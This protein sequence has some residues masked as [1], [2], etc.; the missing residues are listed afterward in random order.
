MHYQVN[1]QL[2]P[3]RTNGDGGLEAYVSY[4]GIAFQCYAPQDPLTIEQQTTGQKRKVTVDTQKLIDRTAKTV[5]L[6]GKGNQIREWVLLTPSFDDKALLEHVNQRAD[7]IRRVAADHDWCH[8]DFRISVHTDR[9]FAA[10]L[11]ALSA[12]KQGLLGIVDSPAASLTTGDAADEGG[13]SFEQAL[14]DKLEVDPSLRANPKRLEH[15]IEQT[16]GAYVSGAV[17][18]DRLARDAPTAH[19]AILDCA[20]AVFGSLANAFVESD[21][22]QLLV[23]RGIREDLLKMIRVEAPALRQPLAELIANYF[24]A[25][26][27][28]KCPLYLEPDTVELASA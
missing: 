19:R 11:A 1:V 16:L 15:Y 23:V 26:W 10:E 3:D 2:I 8:D 25:D 18:L 28:L 14:R 7:E 12:S 22:K 17:Q 9:L 20:G 24:I 6:I 4:E 21:V 13:Q 27:W 5:K